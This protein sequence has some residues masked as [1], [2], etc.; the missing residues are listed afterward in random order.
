M[1]EYAK[2]AKATL[3]AEIEALRRAAARIGAD[4]ERAVELIFG[5]SGKL[6]VSGL[7][8]SGIVGQKIAATLA[9]TG[10]PA[11]FVH[12][13]EALHGDFGKVQADDVAMFLSKSG[14]T[15]EVVDLF[16]VVRGKGHKTIAVVGRSRSTLAERCDVF[17]DASVE[18]E[19][20]PLNLAPTSSS[21]VAMAL[22]DALAACLMH[23]RGFTAEDFARLHPSGSLGK[24]LHLRVHD[25]MHKGKALPVVRPGA[26][27]TEALLTMSASGMGA[28]L[29]ASEDCQLL[30]ILTDGDVRRCI[31]RLGGVQDLPVHDVMIK[32]PVV[33]REDE[34]AVAAVRLM[35]DR[36]SQISVLPVLD[37]EQRLVGILR[38]H[39]LVRAGL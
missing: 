12:P 20:C 2:V 27:M 25:L 22:G 6:I 26:S 33:I 16:Q 13:V 17:L 38:I 19:A 36:P 37:R 31:A 29:I 39:D 11:M 10:T 3:S 23:R 24:R 21:T 30:G 15:P 35:E 5:A 7:G 28:V 32:R 18:Q 14:E 1:S 9:S 4:F 8:K 34:M